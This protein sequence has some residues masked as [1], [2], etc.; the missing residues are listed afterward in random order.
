MNRVWFGT[1]PQRNSEAFAYGIGD[2]SPFFYL[3]VLLFFIAEFRLGAAGLLSRVSRVTA[4]DQRSE[5][6]RSEL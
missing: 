4:L 3:T 6:S 2:K 5:A 1:R